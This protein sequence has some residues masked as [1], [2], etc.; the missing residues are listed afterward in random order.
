VIPQQTESDT[1]GLNFD[2]NGIYQS[3]SQ[4]TSQQCGTVFGSSNGPCD[5][6]SSK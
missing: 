5:K 4:M 2:R 3:E 1:V 6:S